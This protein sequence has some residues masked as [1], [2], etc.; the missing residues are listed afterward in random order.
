[1]AADSSTPAAAPAAPAAATPAAERTSGSAGSRLASAVLV[2]PGVVWLLILFLVPLLIMVVISFGT[3]DATGQVVLDQPTLDNYARTLDVSFVPTFLNSVRY[4]LIV[5]VL[6]LVIGYPVA[7]WISRYGGAHKALLIV[8]VMLPFWTSYIIRTYAWMIMLRDNG[9]V[10]SILQALGITSEP[11]ILLNTDF[12][13]ILGM[14]Y[15]F[16][17]FAILPLFVSIDR[18]DASLV[19]AARD[20]YASGR[21]AFLHV[22][23]PLTM[24]GII[25]AAILTFIPAMGDFVTPDLLGGAE[26]TT[27]AK[28]IQGVF[29]Q[30][31]DW[32]YGAALGLVLMLVTLG[33]T[34]VAIGPLRREVAGA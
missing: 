11:I 16:L 13:V 32:P 6:S 14:T 27:I 12:S 2:L 33:G 19:A 21:S 15:G 34:I 7:Y 25:A 5:T 9:V 10:N 8:I 22:T 28:V 18:L 29:L 17:P 20:L 31:R 4:S 23:L 3:S 26:T 24:P 1:V 30:G